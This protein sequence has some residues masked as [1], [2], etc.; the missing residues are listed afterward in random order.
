VSQEGLVPPTD[1]QAAGQSVGAQISTAVVHLIHE[2]TG[3]GPTKARTTINDGLVTVLL[4]DSML[5]AERRLA[6][7]GHSDVVLEMR[8]RFQHTMRDELSAVVT[9]LTG[10]RVI[11]FMSA[12]HLDPDL[13][14]EIF[15]LESHGSDSPE[16]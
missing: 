6:A 12:N 3:R 2:Y 14:V 7:E 8:R 15:V 13:A 4:G 9:R 1:E 11:A 5:K 16:G 10:R